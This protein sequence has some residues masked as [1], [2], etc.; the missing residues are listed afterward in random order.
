VFLI[1]LWKI[2]LA[3]VSLSS[4]ILMPA[5]GFNPIGAAVRSINFE[6]SNLDISIPGIWDVTNDDDAARLSGEGRIDQVVAID[7]SKTGIMYPLFGLPGQTWDDMIEYRKAHP[8]L[9]WIAIINPLNGPGDPNYVFETYVEKMQE[10]NIQVLGYVSTYWS[11]VPL[12]TIKDDID[13]YKEYFGVDGIFL[14]EMSNRLDDVDH[15]REI[16]TYARSVGMKYVVG[17]TGTD[18]APDYVDIVDNIVISEGYGEPTLSRLAGWHVPH[19]RDNFSYIAYNRNTVDPQYVITSTHFASY[20]YITDDYLPN[21]YDKMPSHFDALLSLLDPMAQN[22]MRNVVV[23]SV[24]LAGAPINGTLAISQQSEIVAS[25]GEWIT[26]VG[27]IGDAYEVGA[28]NDSNYV[29][30][31]WEDGSVLP[32]RTVALGSS[33]I[34]LTAY[35]ITRDAPMKPGATINAMTENGAALSM[36][37]V[38]ESEGQVVESGF[39]PLRFTGNPGQQY[40]I[41]VSDWEHRIFDRWMD[42]SSANPRTLTYSGESFLTAYFHYDS[43]TDAHDTLTI[44]TYDDNG[45]ILTMWTDIRTG[46]SVVDQGYTPLTVPVAKGETYTVSVADWEGL[47]FDRWE[48]GTETM[49]ID[50]TIDEPHESLTAYYRQTVQE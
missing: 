45:G 18:A 14:D 17:N 1:G 36:W 38:I 43:P 50:I 31:H 49:S 37:T 3:L 5:L 8:S 40:Y 47:V 2:A 15:Y 29:F 26:R 39:T 27:T 13:K 11:A 9:P 46:D 34:V 44:N 35:Y 23:K 42:G 32:T 30:A 7:Y 12:E 48:N 20:I 4:M 10:A 41:Y 6:A 21:P 33:S 24:D 25:G 28:L 22:D 16:S 19:G